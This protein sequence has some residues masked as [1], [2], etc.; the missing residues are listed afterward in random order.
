V[1]LGSLSQLVAA[2]SI[3]VYTEEFDAI[4]DHEFNVSRQT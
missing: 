1:I 3:T 4:H 2:F